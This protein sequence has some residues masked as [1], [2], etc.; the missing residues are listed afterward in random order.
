MP[1]NKPKLND[2][3]ILEELKN[4][5]YSQFYN[6]LKLQESDYIIDEPIET[7]QFTSSGI[8]GVAGA[9]NKSH[10]KIILKK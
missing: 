8:G 9:P 5:C 7:Y 1:I 4:S 6:N 2:L 10:F 3:N